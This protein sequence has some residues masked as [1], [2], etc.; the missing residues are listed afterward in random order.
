MSAMIIANIIIAIVCH[1][2]DIPLTL[3]HD[4][5]K[6]NL[7]IEKHINGYLT[8]PKMDLRLTYCLTVDRW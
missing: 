1:E 4:F 3:K 8:R 6:E 7:L 2:L 5:F